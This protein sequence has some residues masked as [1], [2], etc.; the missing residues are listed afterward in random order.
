[1]LEI[2]N[3]TYYGN[4]I[5]EWVIALTLIAL[6]IIVGKILYWFSS[7]IL[8]RLT[9]KTETKLDDILINMIEEP[10]I[11]VGV[12]VCIWYSIS[13]LN[14]S[15]NAQNIVNNILYILIIFNIA[16][17]ITRTVGALVEHYIVP[18]TEQS[19]TDLDD[20]LLP[21]I[22][23]CFNFL[24]WTIAIIVGLNNAGYNL[25]A[26]LAGMGI[27]GLAVAMASKETITNL[28][29]GF[30]VMITRPFKVNERIRVSG[31]DGW[32]R[33]INLNKTVVTDFRGR[34]H[35]IPNR[36]FIDNIIENVDNEKVYYEVERLKLRYDTNPSQIQIAKAILKK[37]IVENELFDNHHWIT[38]DKIGD[39]SFDIEFWYGIKKWYPTDKPQYAD[40]YE[41]KSF[42]KNQLH[43]SILKQ[44]EKNEL[45]FALPMESRV[46]PASKTTSLFSDKPE[47][48]DDD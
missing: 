36:V 26:I 27:G 19:E 41:K 40:W 32:V 4:S 17:L 7:T 42:A 24:I 16:W 31:V 18:L 46:F 28:I 12:L 30:T 47:H 43:I 3:K 15:S 2:I 38:F 39:Y 6:S 1:M 11:M 8:K 10:L 48:K 23:T 37:I 20:V 22:R 29:G 35:I 9:R 44:F 5:N 21:I 33:N 14:I 25:G 45:K 34:A 13:T